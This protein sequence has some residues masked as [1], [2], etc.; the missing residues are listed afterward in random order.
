MSKPKLFISYKRN[1]AE[2]R[3]ALSQVML[4]ASDAGFEARYDDNDIE[5]GT[6]W[7]IEIH[8]MIKESAVVIVLFSK[9]AYESP[10]VIHEWSYAMGC[11]VR[12]IPILLPSMN[13]AE[14]QLA[15]PI[16]NTQML[17]F[18]QANYQWDRLKGRLKDIMTLES[19]SNTTPPAPAD[20]NP[21]QQLVD[22]LAYMLDTSEVDTVPLRI[23]LENLAAIGLLDADEYEALSKKLRQL[24][25]RIA[26]S[27]R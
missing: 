19:A 11:G 3:S 17:D 6:Q 13:D 25:N 1:D 12:I 4:L 10:F 23:V 24:Y 26:S 18:R 15:L 2:C 8:R 20:S 14:T 16:H 21:R 27:E 7:Q 22:M 5:A 9:A